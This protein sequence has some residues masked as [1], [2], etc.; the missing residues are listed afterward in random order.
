[1]KDE[2]GRRRRGSVQATLNKRARLIGQLDNFWL[3]ELDMVH[4]KRQQNNPLRGEPYRGDLFQ[5]TQRK[6]G[7]N[8]AFDPEGGSKLNRKESQDFLRRAKTI[9]HKSIP[10]GVRA[11][12]QI[13]SLP[14]SL[15]FFVWTEGERRGVTFVR[16]IYP[17]DR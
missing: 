13:Q 6:R 12:F 2:E 1:L 14:F 7:V 3:K 16:L 15:T 5:G 9:F 11:N 10:Q 8:S 4:W 17:L